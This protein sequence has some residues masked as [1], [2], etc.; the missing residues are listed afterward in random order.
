[1]DIVIFYLLGIIIGFIGSK[2]H[3]HFRTAKATLLIDH[4][5][6]EKDIYR[7]DVDDLNSFYDHKYLMM[8]IDHNADLRKNNNSYYE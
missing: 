2:I 3:T 7:L 6:S 8:K 1:M 5:D 4:A